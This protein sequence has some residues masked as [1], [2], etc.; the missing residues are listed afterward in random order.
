MKPTWPQLQKNAQ[1]MIDIH[2]PESKLFSV[3]VRQAMSEPRRRANFQ[4]VEHDDSTKPGVTQRQKKRVF[5]L[6][7][8]WRTIDENESRLFQARENIA[9][10][11]EIE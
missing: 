11:F 8:I 5:A 4:I 2:A 9:I 3:L 7:R 1:L 6:G 10:F